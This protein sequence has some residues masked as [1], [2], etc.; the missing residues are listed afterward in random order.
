MIA[1][2]TSTVSIPPLTAEV[3]SFVSCTTPRAVCA[4]AALPASASTQAIDQK[5]FRMMPPNKH[6]P[7][8]R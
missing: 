5:P 4:H 2:F 7:A 3:F 8:R 6:F 1:V